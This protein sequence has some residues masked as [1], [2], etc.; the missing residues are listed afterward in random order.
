MPTISPAI[1][2]V[3]SINAD[4]SSF[5]KRHPAPGETIHGTGGEI[6]PGGKGANQAVAAANLGASV[7]MVGAVGSDPNAKPALSGLE[8]SGVVLDHITDVEGPTGVAI[9]TVAEDGENTIVVIP[10]ANGTMNAAAVEAKRDVIGAA[11][12][13]VAQGEIPR[14]GIEAIP[15]LVNGRFLFNPAPVL[16][17]SLDTF[18]AAN[19]LVVNEHEAE[20]V[21]EQ[22]GHSPAS[23]QDA[24]QR[25]LGEGIESIVLTLGAQGSVVYTAEDEVEIPAVSVTAVDTTGAGDAFI[26]ALAAKLASG[27]SLEDAARFASRV[28][29]YAV[30]G[31]GAQPSY[32]T[33]DDQLPG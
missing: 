13:V 19:P 29:A 33:K 18:R 11:Q 22:F 8:A 20:L 27:D 23:P 16:D 17:L 1:V 15:A 4:L 12:V 25:L 14:D 30:T 5:V 2:V 6:T 7:A 31:K 21:A 10:G 26:G 24:A 3:G 28:G 32:P 9:V